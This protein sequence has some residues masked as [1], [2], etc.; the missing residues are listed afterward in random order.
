MC[1]RIQKN[2]QNDDNSQVQKFTNIADKRQIQRILDQQ[3]KGQKMETAIHGF[4]KG[5]H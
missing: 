1:D 2:W 4:S 3:S 5:A